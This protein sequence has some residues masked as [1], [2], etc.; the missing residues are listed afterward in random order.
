[1]QFQISTEPGG[2][3]FSASADQTILEAALA[4]GVLLPYGCRDGACGACKGQ[5]LSGEIEQGPVA[6]T[7]LSAAERASGQALLCKAHPRTDLVIRVRNVGHVGDIPS[8]KLPCRVE[9]LE[10]VASDV[11]VVRLKLPASEPFRFRAGQ[12]VD[13]LLADGRRRSFSIANP[14]ERSD[15]L[16]LHVRKIDGGRFT[17][18]VFEA[19][20]P[21]DILRF[22]GPL[23][24]FFLREHV[25]RPIILLA[26]GTGFAPIKSIVEHVIASGTPR[27]M[28][29][30]W[31]ARRREGL[32]MDALARSWETSLPDFRYVP[33]LSEAD[34]DEDWNGRRGLVHKAVMADHPDLSAHEVYACGAPAMISAAHSDLVV[35]CGLPDEFF[36]ADAFT[37]AAEPANRAP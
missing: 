7:A 6:D 5:V 31:G 35:D 19:M 33:V 1:M 15:H 37:F 2:Q 9:S 18:Q 16:E 12:Y 20:K 23:G 22:E 32:Y 14:P 24:T 25:D 29:L 4:A 26:G 30:Y 27:T 8:K 11:M 34:V 36:F 10:R 13:F 28:T 3:H 17:T 21:R